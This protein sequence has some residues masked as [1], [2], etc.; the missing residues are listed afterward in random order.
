MVRSRYLP[1]DDSEYAAKQAQGFWRINKNKSLVQ[2]AQSLLAQVRQK[3]AVR[4]LHVK[5]HSGHM[6]NDR[7][8]HLA[9][10]GAAGGQCAVGRWADPMQAQQAQQAP[11]SVPMAQQAPPHT[12][13][14]REAAAAAGGGGGSGNASG[15]AKRARA[16]HCAASIAPAEAAGE[17]TVMGKCA[18]VGREL[19]LSGSIPEVVESA[20]ALLG[21]PT[22]GASLVQNLDAC[23]AKLFSRM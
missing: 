3:R 14:K 23:Y 9:N 15:D 11:V 2:R 13:V 21:V 20:C 7:A 5:G 18:A 19:Q 8:D 6:W 17:Q 12:A 22:A 4:F 10:T 16:M 1:A